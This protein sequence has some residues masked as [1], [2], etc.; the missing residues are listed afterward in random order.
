[1]L[2]YNHPNTFTTK[3][4]IRDHQCNYE[5]M[6]GHGTCKSLVNHYFGNNLE[7]SYTKCAKFIQIIK[8][9]LQLF[10]TAMPDVEIND[11][12]V[13]HRKY[14]FKNNETFIGDRHN[15]YSMYTMI[16]Y[17]RID[18]SIIGGE[19]R[20]YSDKDG[21]KNNRAIMVSQ[22]SVIIFSGDHRVLPIKSKGYGERNLLILF[23]NGNPQDK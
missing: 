20:L 21:N 17:Y 15:D 11:F 7:D 2:H 23:I 1:M 18:E 3:P 4:M 13:E 5:S 10:K 16:F 14:I 6:L 19:L 9:M 12:S 8:P 22:G